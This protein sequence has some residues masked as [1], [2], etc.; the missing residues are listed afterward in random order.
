MKRHGRLYTA[1][2]R[3]FSPLHR[4][5]PFHRELSRVMDRNPPGRVVLNLGSG[6]FRLR[7]CRHAVNL[8]FQPFPEVD[9]VA[10]VL[11][12]PLRDGCA[13]LVL[14]LD[15]LEHVPDPRRLMRETF[16]VLRPGGETLA[17]I[18]F[19]YP[20]HLA[21][22]DYRRFTPQ[23]LEALYGE[24]SSCRVG[25]ASG[26]MCATLLALRDLA[27]T[28]GSLGWR[29]MYDLLFVLFSVAAAPFKVLDEALVRLPT[30]GHAAGAFFVSA[31]K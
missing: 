11:A 30:A 5:R 24:F 25:V 31:V 18:P 26:P 17:F 15:L 23:G 20:V 12:L 8:D 16:R 2:R 28:A 10:D 4:C 29:P 6:P 27:A 7:R 21:P 22:A 14:N 13:D 3:T 9:V 19:L 1:L